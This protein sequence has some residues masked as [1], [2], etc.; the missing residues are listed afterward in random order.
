MKTLSC[1]PRKQQKVKQK[2]SVEN[3]TENLKTNL[4]KTKQKTKQ[5]STD[6]FFFN[7]KKQAST[8]TKTTSLKLPE[9]Q[10]RQ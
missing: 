10:F 4:K 5:A 9:K 8:K 3:Q 2:E 6:F 7:T 1:V